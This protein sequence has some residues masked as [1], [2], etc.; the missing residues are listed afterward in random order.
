MRQCRRLSNLDFYSLCPQ[1]KTFDELWNL[2]L[3]VATIPLKDL[4]SCLCVTL[5]IGHR[6]A[7]ENF[8]PQGNDGWGVEAGGEELR[9]WSSYSWYKI[10]FIPDFTF[11]L[12]GIKTLSTFNDTFAF[13][14][15]RTSF[16]GQRCRGREVVRSRSR[17]MMSTWTTQTSIFIHSD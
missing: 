9:T 4:I 3:A 10:A 1:F 12:L 13:N 7:S 14:G 16:G 5:N 2:L 15:Q 8:S 17:S 11:L 6:S